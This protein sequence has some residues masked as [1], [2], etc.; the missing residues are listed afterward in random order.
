MYTEALELR[1][2]EL[3]TYIRIHGF[4]ASTESAP[5]GYIWVR[6]SED[7]TPEYVKASALDVRDW[8]GY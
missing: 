6:E 2:E 4:Q 8:L 3:V 5:D 7:T 1:T